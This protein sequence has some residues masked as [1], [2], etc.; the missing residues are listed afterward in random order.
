MNKLI[1]ILL[2]LIGTAVQAQTSFEINGNFKNTKPNTIVFIMNGADGKTIATDTVRDGSFKLKGNLTEADIYQIGFIGYKEG[3][4][5]FLYNNQVTIEG[6]FNDM[7]NASIKGS[8]LN[9]DYQLFKA[10]FNPIREE[11]NGLAAL[12]NAEKNKSPRDSMIA[13]FEQAKSK[14]MVE[15]SNFTKEKNTSPVSP[16][17]LYVIS[18][19]LNGPLDL[20]YRYNELNQLA[21]QGSF[22][23]VLEKIIAES[24]VNGIGTVAQNFSQKDTAGKLVS[25]ASFKGK[26]VLLDFWASWCGPCRAENPNVVAAY[27]LFKDKK[28]TVVGVS[29]DESRASWL[30]AIKKDKLF[31]T[32]LSDLK[33][34]YN[35]AARLYKVSS[36]PANFLIDPNGIIIAKDL[37]G[38]ALINTLNSVLK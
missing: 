21:K 19:L 22:A 13:L 5:L 28:F 37:R 20:E 24:K 9:L 35:E 12:I 27:N 15:A 17:V 4:D 31:W 18:P 7:G 16:F 25:L 34:F 23:R 36:I 26:Y 6:D 29:L 38:D 11:L 8:P 3:I 33:Y 10:R 2:F 32:Q 14:V 30:Q 1:A